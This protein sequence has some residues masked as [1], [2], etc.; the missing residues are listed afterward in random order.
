MNTYLFFPLFLFPL[1]YVPHTRTRHKL[2]AEVDVRGVQTR[3]KREMA[4]FVCVRPSLNYKLYKKQRKRGWICK[5][6][7]ARQLKCE[8]KSDEMA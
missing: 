5:T 8:E 3:V 4:S 7:K 2:P 6:S 1:L